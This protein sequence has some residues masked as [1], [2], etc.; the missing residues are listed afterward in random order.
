MYRECFATFSLPFRDTE[1]TQTQGH[2]ILL[3]S[4]LQLPASSARKW[5]QILMAALLKFVLSTGNTKCYAVVPPFSPKCW[6]ASCPAELSIQYAWDESADCTEQVQSPL[7]LL[8]AAAVVAHPLSPFGEIT[9]LSLACFSVLSLTSVPPS[10]IRHPQSQIRNLFKPWHS[11]PQNPTFKLK[12][13]P[14]FRAQISSLCECKWN[15]SFPLWPT[16]PLGRGHP[17]H[18]IHPVHVLGTTLFLLLCKQPPPTT[19][20]GKRKTNKTH[21]VFRLCDTRYLTFIYYNQMPQ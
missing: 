16:H 12:V 1:T 9:Q 17:I 14:N 8:A 11:C 4:Q 6:S 3:E 10:A 13:Y 15:V 18:S 19:P 5:H 2:C 20:A 21:Q 7:D